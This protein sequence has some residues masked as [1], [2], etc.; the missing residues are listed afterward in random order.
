M[1]RLILPSLLC[2]LLCA[3]AAPQPPTSEQLDA[4]GVKNGANAMDAEHALSQEGY[5]CDASGA[6][7]ENLNCSK[8]K[9]AY[10]TLAGCIVRVEFRVSRNLVEN[11]SVPE[12]ACASF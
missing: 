6:Q 12:V 4:I 11:L 9:S 8:M 7:H 2:A 10:L 5:H 3:C 1:K